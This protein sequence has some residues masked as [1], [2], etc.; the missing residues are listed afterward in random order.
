MLPEP[1]VS[2]LYPENVACAEQYLAALSLIDVGCVIPV[3]V[4]GKHFFNPRLG[5]IFDAARSMYGEGKKVDLVT[6]GDCLASNR[7]LHPCGG[8]GYLATIAALYPP[9]NL[10]LSYS[11]II[12]TAWTTR[13]LRRITAEVPKALAD[14]A[15]VQAIC[16]RLRT[17]LDR[18]ETASDEGCV[19]LDSELLEEISRIIA[20]RKLLSEG[21]ASKAGLPLGLPGIEE[22]IP[23]QLPRDRVTVIFGETG[24]FKTGLKHTLSDAIAATGA[25]VLDFSLED[26]PELT[27]QRYL[28]RCTGIPYGKIASRILTDSEVDQLAALSEAATEVAKRTIVVGSVPGT[29]EEAI[30]L[31]RQYA[32][33]VPL[34]AV[35]LDYIQLVARDTRAREDVGVRQIMEQVQQAAKRDKLAWV[36]VSQM[37][38]RY[39]DRT[40]RRPLLSD[41]FGGSAIEQL[42]KLAFG[43]YR[44]WASEPVPTEESVFHRMYSN[45]PQGK[46][47]YKNALELWVRKQVNGSINECIPVLVHPPTGRMRLFRKDEL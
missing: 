12:H 30:R 19:S 24:T 13:E 3:S 4:A 7:M 1:A 10:S 36:V 5:T 20:D 25:Y 6:V 26:S 21:K 46:E 32:A 28:S 42:C 44:P 16:T 43:L 47:M 35:F 40:D 31:S 14:G 33:K 18:L 37:N 41:M 11:E 23:Q 2:E 34:A 39:S 27:A 22:Y 45:H 29:V 9:S 17:F 15:S 38:R 8:V